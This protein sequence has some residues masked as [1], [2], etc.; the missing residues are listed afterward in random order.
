MRTVRE[1]L[2]AADPV[3]REPTVSPAKFDA[4]RRAALGATS[5][6]ATHIGGRSRSRIAFLAAAGLMLIAIA[7]TTSRLWSP[8]IDEV[9]G[10]VRFEVRL[11]EDKPGPGL[12]EAKDDAGHSFYLH[13]E[14]VVDNSDITAAKVTESGSP[15]VYAVSVTFNAAGTQK[16]REATQG[17][18]GKTLAILL[19]GRVVMAPVL[20]SEISNSA[21]ITGHFTKAQAER[22]A[23]GIGKE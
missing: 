12:Q 19:D 11:A 15:P 10:A 14:I 18:I 21:A 16:M 5:E 9:Q 4:M 1:L 7:S 13:S 6:T 20:R 22:I 3:G 23:N 17:H 8:F 2:R